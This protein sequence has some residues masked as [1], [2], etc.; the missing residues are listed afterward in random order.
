M[1]QSHNLDTF[2]RSIC[3][4]VSLADMEMQLLQ[5]HAWQTLVSEK[6]ELT[7]TGQESV[8]DLRRAL[9]D[10]L[11]TDRHLAMN[12]VTVS[13]TL[14][15]RSAWSRLWHRIRHPLSKSNPE[16]KL[17]A[18]DESLTG[19]SLQINFKRQISGQWKIDQPEKSIEL[20]RMEFLT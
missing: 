6:I 15:K 4:D 1:S 16:F 12:E 10:E 2:L 7:M 14:A 19:V 20:P 17:T 11:G 13:F 3:R 9:L 18:K 5:H 8:E